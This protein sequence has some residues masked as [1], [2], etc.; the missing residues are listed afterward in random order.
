MLLCCGQAFI[1]R[2]F[3]V[4]VDQLRVQ[5]IFPG[6][7]RVVS[8][9]EAIDL[10]RKLTIS[11]FLDVGGGSSANSLSVFSSLGGEAR[12]LTCVGNDKLG[13]TFQSDLR[14]V[15]IDV[16]AEKDSSYATGLCLVAVSEGGVRSMF[17]SL[18]AAA[19][20]DFS[21]NDFEGAGK[22]D[23]LLVEAYNFFSSASNL[24]ERLIL[25]ATARNIS[26]ALSLSDSGVVNL[27]RSEIL[28]LI[29]RIDLLIGNED[30]F[31]A[32]D[33]GDLVF[34][35]TRRIIS[36]SSNGVVLIAAGDKAQ[37]GQLV[38]AVSVVATDTTGAGDA[39]TGAL[40]YGEFCGLS[41]IESATRAV[42]VA[43][44]VVTTPGAR[45]EKGCARAAWNKL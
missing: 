27:K 41:P 10:Q 6:A 8:P 43:A 9:A 20:L 1:D 28:A 30:E 21:A 33:V 37:Q 42:A 7:R 12:F 24:V 40:L 17:T 45:I 36:R 31:A 44:V 3:Y 15:G 26:V 5:G 18:G 25:A 14:Y 38:P 4:P 32:L 22:G 19:N 39:L 2:I 11:S 35:K 16:R 34:A 23:W 29:D 13:E